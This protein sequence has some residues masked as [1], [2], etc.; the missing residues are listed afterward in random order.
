M[1]LRVSGG[2]K[3]S[4]LCPQNISYDS[5]PPRPHPQALSGTQS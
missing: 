5:N 3:D 4:S 2:P 1:I